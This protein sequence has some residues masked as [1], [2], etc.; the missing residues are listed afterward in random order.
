MLQEYNYT[1][2]THWIEEEPVDDRRNCHECGRVE[3]EHEM[4]QLENF[5]PA[6]DNKIHVCGMCMAEIIFSPDCEKG[7]WIITSDGFKHIWSWHKK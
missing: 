1:N 7:E 4:H 2:E 5:Y 6:P 3:L